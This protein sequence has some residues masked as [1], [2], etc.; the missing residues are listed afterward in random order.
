[1]DDNINMAAATDTN[2]KLTSGLKVVSFN[3]HGFNQGSPTVQELITAHQPNILL[4]QEHWCTPEN[5]SK[6]DQYVDYFTF[7]MSAMHKSVEIGML[8]GRPFG[9]VL[10]MINNNIRH[11]TETI[12]C[13]ER[14]NIV[15]VDK[16]II[17]NVYLPCVGTVDREIICQD[18]LADIVSWRDRFADCEWLL[19]GDF[20]TDLNGTDCVAKLLNNFVAEHVLHRSD[21]LFN[22][23]GKATYVND[24]LNHCSCIDYML[25][26]SCDEIMHFDVLDPDINLSDHLPLLAVFKCDFAD[27]HNTAAAAA[28]H[29]CDARPV[30]YRWDHADLSAYYQFIGH[31]LQPVL[32]RL[33]S[34]VVQFNNHESIDCVAA[35]DACYNDVV[36]VLTT[37]AQTFVPQHRKNF[38]KFWWDEELNLLKEESINSD[39]LWKAAGKPR[40]GPI[41]DRRQLCRLQYRRR[42]REGE[43]SNLTAYTNDLHECLLEKNGAD[44]WKCWRSKFVSSNK[45]EQVDGCVDSII[46]ADKFA[47]HFSAAYSSTNA[48]Q[49]D[50]LKAEYSQRRADYFGDALSEQQLFDTELVGNIIADLKRGKAA[51]PDNL[52]AD[53]LIH[54]HPILSSILTKLFN[55]MLLCSH[56]P[57]SFGLSYTIPIPKIKDCRTKSMTTDDFRGIAISCVLSKVL[58]LCIYDRFKQFFVVSD[59]QFGFKKGLGCS[60]AIYTVRNAVEQYLKGGST[61]NLC[62]LDLSKAYDKTNHHALF[63]KLM[64]RNLPVELL[65]MFEHWFG[66]CWTFVKWGSSSSR[67]FRI[68]FG[69]RQGSVLSPHLFAV[70]LDDIV[71]QFCPGRGIYIVLYADDILLIAPSVGELQRL[72]DDC[73]VELNYLDM[74]INVKKSCCI[75]IGPRCDVLCAAIVTS[76]GCSLPWV[77][78]IRYLGIFI[79]RSRVFKCSLEYAKRACYRSLNAI[80]GKI[81]RVASEEVTLELVAKK[82]L[83]VLLYGLEACPLTNAD[84]K[85]L[86]FVVTR[87]LM[88]LFKTVNNELIKECQ[89]FFKFQSPSEL[90]NLRTANFVLK[91]KRCD[92]LLCSTFM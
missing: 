78:K 8:K 54:S 80:F 29:A 70:Y 41:F 81:G 23:V 67:F 51:G 90:L 82:C 6:F 47:A 75:R 11:I 76:N 16:L 68:E 1:M 59:N 56:V 84:K 60:H 34:V 66:N 27:V 91:Y 31:A 52:T 42:L 24:A 55:L 71:G 63:I 77:D 28:K 46:V 86:D 9:G 57:E 32:D 62:A 37:G 74:S 79:V 18:L 14:C 30:H 58:E 89:V 65:R 10:T 61:V 25:I 12:Y 26:S 40:Q 19:A 50:A 33:D 85:S 43:R 35:I 92:N 13:S 36:T 20:N 44:F 39:K 22:K 2:N 53:H 87:F 17:V 73:E 69:V 64:N 88:K 45:C 21:I 3:M 38:Y 48:T 7:G 4:L 83:P 15:R 72:L 5:L 49:A